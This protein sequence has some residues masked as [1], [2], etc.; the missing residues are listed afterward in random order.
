MDTLLVTMQLLL[1]LPAVPLAA[2][3]WRS[4]R[5]LRARHQGFLAAAALLGTTAGLLG[6]VSLALAF[7]QEAPVDGWLLFGPPVTTLLLCA[8]VVRRA[9]SVDAAWARHRG[10]AHNS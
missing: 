7:G 2:M 1:L 3:S 6:L 5:A 4:S 10:A 9:L 8:A